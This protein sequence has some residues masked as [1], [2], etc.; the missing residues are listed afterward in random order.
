VKH[1]F[2]HRGGVE[3]AGDVDHELGVRDEALDVLAG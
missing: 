3:Q 2:G 1:R